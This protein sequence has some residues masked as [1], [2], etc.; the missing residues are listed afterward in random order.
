GSL[1][2]HRSKTS[3]RRERL[4]LIRPRI[5]AINGKPLGQ[6]WAELVTTVLNVTWGDSRP[7]IAGDSLELADSDGQT[8]LIRRPVGAVNDNLPIRVGDYLSRDRP[9]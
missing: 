2:S 3:N 5:V 8:R 6:S 9:F 7:M 4:F 1:F